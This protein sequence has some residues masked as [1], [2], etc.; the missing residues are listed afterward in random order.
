[1][2]KLICECIQM[3]TFLI[4]FIEL[5][6]KH[7]CNSRDQYSLMI[8]A[9]ILI[10]NLKMYLDYEYAIISLFWYDT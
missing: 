1:M 7:T 9:K 4:H 6:W 5:L 10:T 8:V 3:L 2:Q